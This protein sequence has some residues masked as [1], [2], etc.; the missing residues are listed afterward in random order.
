MAWDK[1]SANDSTFISEL[2]TEF[3]PAGIKVSVV[4]I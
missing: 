3:G 2:G 1:L 4:V